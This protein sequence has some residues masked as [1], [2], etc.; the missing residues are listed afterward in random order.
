[1]QD[2]HGEDRNQVFMFSLESS[3]PSDSFVRVVDAFVDT[4]DLK[5][6]G[7]FRGGFPCNRSRCISLLGAEKLIGVLKKSHWLYFL[8]Q[9]KR[10]LSPFE[11]SKTIT[12]K[13]SIEM[14]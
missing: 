12:G 4:I 13:Y 11:V 9:T 10:I 5:S 2:I 1:M 6:F 14:I 3:I 7:F 8:A